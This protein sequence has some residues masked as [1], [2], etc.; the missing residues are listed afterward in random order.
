M[1]HNDEIVV[2]LVNLTLDQSPTVIVGSAERF[3]PD[4][5]VAD[6][7]NGLRCGIAM[8]PQVSR[9]ELA[10]ILA[11]LIHGSSDY[12]LHAQRLPGSRARIFRSPTSATDPP[13]RRRWN[14]IVRPTIPIGGRMPVRCCGAFRRV[15]RLRGAVSLSQ[16]ARHPPVAGR[17]TRPNSPTLRVA[18]KNPI[19]NAVAAIS[20]SRGPMIR[21]AFSSSA[22]SRACSRAS[23][24][25]NGATPKSRITPLT[26]RRRRSRTGSV[27]ARSHPCSSSAA[28]IAAI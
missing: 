14:E 18:T 27:F 15:W 2:A 16:T 4:G 1:S 19:A 6:F 11:L 8:V 20:L 17:G 13:S 5:E 28:V 9:V 25:V 7:E 3:H 12:R 26:K 21:P 22:H 10:K 24:S 23:A